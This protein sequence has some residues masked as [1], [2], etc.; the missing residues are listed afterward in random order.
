MV[1]RC[2]DD[3]NNCDNN[4]SVLFG[5]GRRPIWLTPPC[6]VRTTSQ[7]ALTTDFS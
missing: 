4:R 7:V 3:E 6:R 5:C 2:A 1:E